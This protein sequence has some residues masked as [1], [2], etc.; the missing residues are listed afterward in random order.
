MVRKS[1]VISIARNVTLRK[2]KLQSKATCT[3][4]G[5][6]LVASFCQIDFQKN[7][8]KNNSK[9]INPTNQQEQTAQ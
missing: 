4:Q 3:A 1:I 6:L 8:Q 2:I 5:G 9:V 7:C